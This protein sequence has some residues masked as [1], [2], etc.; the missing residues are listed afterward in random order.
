MQ[1]HLLSKMRQSESRFLRI[2]AQV[3]IIMV[4]VMIMIRKIAFGLDDDTENDKN[5]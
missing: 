2:L 5:D 4:L 3:F 1:C